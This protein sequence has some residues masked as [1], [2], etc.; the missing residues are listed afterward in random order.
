MAV[1]AVAPAA[2]A[3]EVLGTFDAWTA[4]TDK[5]SGK[6]ICYIGS[7]PKKAEGNY[8]KRD[9][10][11]VLVTHRPAEKVVGEVSVETGYTYKAGSA[12]MVT[13]G[14]RKFTLFSKGSNA[15]AK[16]AAA[17]K[18]LVAAMKSG[19]EMVIKGTSSR[20]T[21]T[22]DTYSLSGFTAAFNAITKAC[23]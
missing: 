3:Q 15:W 8:T 18:D 19:A 23:S 10:A 12:P 22:T 20:G 17:D 2:N 14:D 13:I 6:Q 1:L 4:F 11:F 5:V 9:E 7:K 21:L 16:D